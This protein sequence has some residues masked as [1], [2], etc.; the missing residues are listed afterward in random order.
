MIHTFHIYLCSL[1]VSGIRQDI[2]LL[3]NITSSPKIQA[4]TVIIN[5]SGTTIH[6]KIICYKYRIR[7]KV[8]YM[9]LQISAPYH[10]SP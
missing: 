1:V 4:S 9:L 3:I 2:A 7:A 5:C 10:F 8:P 6:T